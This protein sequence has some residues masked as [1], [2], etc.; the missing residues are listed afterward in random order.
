MTRLVALI[1]SLSVLGVGIVAAPTAQAAEL[2]VTPI[3]KL[4]AIE[5]GKLV[6][7]Q[8]TLVRETTFKSGVRYVVQDETGKAT[9]VLFD[10]VLSRIEPRDHLGEGAVVRAVGKLDFY[11]K[12]VQVVPRRAQDVRIL[13]P[14]PVAEPRAIG[15]LTLDD[16]GKRVRIAGRVLEARNYSNG[17]RFMLADESGSVTL[18]IPEKV[19]DDLAEPAALN[20]GAVL[21]VTGK[22]D[23]IGKDVEIILTAANGLRVAQP[24]PS[25]R[26]VR[27]YALGGMSGNDHNALVRVRG[28][29]Y[30]VEPFDDGVLVLI[31]DGTGAQFLRLW[32]AVAE[33]VSVQPGQTVEVIGRVRAQRRRGIF[34]EP[35]LPHDVIVVVQSVAT[36]TPASP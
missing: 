30:S 2:P 8:G 13:Q 14:A 33:R 24:A 19:Y 5:K 16:K 7:I 27:T 9:L 31:Q 4:A 35:A 3:A 34:I 32:R 12:E 20:V 25:Q 26:E 28:E 10:R 21:T 6:A 23:S 29:V 36:P 17:F 11:R 15:T 18:T 22:V 1:A